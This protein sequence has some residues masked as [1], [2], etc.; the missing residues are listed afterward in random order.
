[1]REQEVPVLH[2]SR[3]ALNSLLELHRESIAPRRL[4][5][6]V[7]ADPYLA[8]KLLRRVESKRSTRLGRETTTPL[9]SVLH[10][11]I[12][13]MAEVIMTGTSVPADNAGQTECHRS[14][15]MASALAR[16][17]AAL[18]ADT[19]PGEVAMAALLAETGELLLWHFAPELPDKVV[20]EMRS[21]RASGAVQAQ[22]QVCGFSF[23]EMTLAVAES[24]QLPKAIT[25][26][27]HGTGTLRANLVRIAS[28]TARHIAANPEHPEIPADILRI[29][30]LLPRASPRQV[31]GPLP[32]SA[33]FK[34]CVMEQLGR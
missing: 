29:R 3:E 15:S 24:M 34:E 22:H 9:A 26:L 14:A 20:E 28:E 31:L 32:V 25:H 21:G 8:L 10:A 23:K 27:I 13:E 18:R 33:E 17:W 6:L 16:D 4:A 19:S 1:M 5:S 2:S 30:E 12:D 7:L 11:G